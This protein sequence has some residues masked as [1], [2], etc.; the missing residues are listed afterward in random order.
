MNS[1]S[2]SAGHLIPLDFDTV[3]GRANVFTDQ[4][5]LSTF[6]RLILGEISRFDGQAR[7]LDVGCGNGL[8][9]NQSAGVS[10]LS[11]IQM[12]SGELWGCE[13]DP[14]IVP[15]PL[16][17][18]FARGTLEEAELP[19]AHFD[20]I[21]AHYV[22]EHVAD[23]KAFLAKAHRLLRPGGRLLFVTP[24][25][26]HYFVKVARIVAAL[27]LEEKVLGL[28]NREAAE[29]HYPTRYLLNDAPDIERAG[30][31]TGF[32]QSEFAYFEHGDIRSYAPRPLR[33]IPIGM[34]KLMQAGGYSRL[35]GLVARMRR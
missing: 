16:L 27:N 26:R 25:E 22:V 2:T 4:N 20:V 28:I 30:R 9:V 31:E 18:H 14:D 21:Y 24:N 1:E 11:E 8:G 13:P 12:A 35:P 3:V 23:P 7:V 34:E 10:A 17:N 29:A 32:S 33:W 5:R 15:S 19:D 6:G